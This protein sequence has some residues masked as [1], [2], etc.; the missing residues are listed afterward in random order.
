M[1]ASTNGKVIT[2]RSGGTQVTPDFEQIETGFVAWGAGFLRKR[3]AKNGTGRYSSVGEL[4]DLNFKTE[5]GVL[6]P[7]ILKVSN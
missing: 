7:G 2:S 4:L 6:F 5:D 1:S 3:S